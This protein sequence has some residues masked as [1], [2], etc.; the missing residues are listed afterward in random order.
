MPDLRVVLMMAFLAV[1]TGG[2]G[3]ADSPGPGE[4][5]AMSPEL[6]EWVLSEVPL[7]EIGVR[8]GEDPYQLHRVRGSVRL[9]DG[10]VVVLNGGSQELRYFDPEGRFLKSVGGMGEGPGEFR[11]PA[12]LRRTHDGNL[13]VWDGSLMRVSIFD[14]EG[15]FQSSSTLLASSEEVFPGDDWL[16]GHDWIVSPVP[17][18]AR[19]PIREAVNRLPAPDSA[20]ILR[21]LRVTPQGRIWSPAVRPPADSAVTWR[22]F[23]LDA[24]PVAKVTTPARFEPHEI[25]EDYLTGLFLD[26]VDVNYVRIYELIKPQGSPPGPGLD[27]SIRAEQ[28]EDGPVLEPPS[29]EVL[30]GIRALL[31]NMASLEE[32]YYANHYT[33]TRD[34]DA[35]LENSRGGIPDD[36]AVD[37]LYAGTEAWAVM[38]S[39][40][41][42][43]GRC[44]MGY[45]RFV[46]MGWQPGAIVCL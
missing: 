20:G 36:L 35:L 19:G 15:A 3:G 18:R 46:P 44:V 34:L 7:L 1:G 8:E 6:E 17:P 31:K 28:A 22:V 5:S 13:Q 14:P 40:P 33:Y 12:G 9:E 16:Q 10:R 38:V 30:A 24:R 21:T 27:L 4:E 42:S 45:G 2:C 32:I 39:H 41:E 43:A 11:G 25:A 26:D 23:D 37:I 29:E